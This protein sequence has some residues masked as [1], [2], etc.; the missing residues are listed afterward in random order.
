VAANINVDKPVRGPAAGLA[1]FTPIEKVPHGVP[2][3]MDSLM[4]NIVLGSLEVQR[5]K[6]KQGYPQEGAEDGQP[7]PEGSVLVGEIGVHKTE[8][9]DH[10]HKRIIAYPPDK[11]QVFP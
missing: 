6:G 2:R 5:I 7:F 9:N 3:I 8:L 1:F 4:K 10:D 11:L